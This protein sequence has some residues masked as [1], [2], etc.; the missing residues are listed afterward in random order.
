LAGVLIGQSHLSPF[1]GAF[2][3]C[4]AN[5]RHRKFWSM[6]NLPFCG[7]WMIFADGEI[8]DNEYGPNPKGMYW[9]DDNIGDIDQ[10]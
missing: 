10:A 4:E 6:A 9:Y 3:V 7:L 1:T 5:N 8:G 2:F